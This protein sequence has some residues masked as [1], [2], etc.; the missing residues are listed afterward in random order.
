MLLAHQAATIDQIS[1]GRLILGVGT[2][3]DVPAIRQ[4]FEATCTPFDKRIGRMLEGLHLAKALWAGG[5]VDWDGRWKVEQ[6]EVAPLPP[7]KGGPPL[8]SG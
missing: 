2:A 6:A 5:P 1:E 7:R 4:E 3:R 8:W